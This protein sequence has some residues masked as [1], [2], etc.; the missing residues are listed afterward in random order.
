MLVPSQICHRIKNHQLVSF[1]ASQILIATTFLTASGHSQ[2]SHTI[3]FQSP[4]SKTYI[5][6]PTTKN[7]M[8]RKGSKFLLIA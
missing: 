7:Y 1:L 5:C 6:T 4:D 3:A 8:H 2:N